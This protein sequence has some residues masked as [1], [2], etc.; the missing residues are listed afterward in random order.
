MLS[1]LL[2]AAASAA[3]FDALLSDTGWEEVD[4]V[5]RKELGTAVVRVKTIEGGRCL[6]GDVTV[7]VP[8]DILL[9]VVTDIPA[10][11]RFSSEKLIAAR[12]LGREGGA[13]HYYQH[14]DVPNWTMAADRY[15][16]LSGQQVTEGDRTSFRWQRFDWRSRYP[17]LAVELDRDHPDAVE[18]VPNWGAWVFQ[19][20]DGRTRARYYLCSDPG[21]SL[22]DWLQKAAA[23]K[24]L[25]N[26]MADVVR[27]AQRR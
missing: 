21:G 9:D 27:E 13:V 25:P 15:W 12:E 2:V 20:A 10:A 24:T 5:D 11:R 26:T 22:P 1:L 14:L 4:R 19:P 17:D 3:D 7:D 16:V 8:V 6:Q 18:P 23:T